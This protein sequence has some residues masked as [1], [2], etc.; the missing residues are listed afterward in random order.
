[1]TE[2]LGNVP[3]GLLLTFFLEKIAPIVYMMAINDAHMRAQQHALDLHGA[4]FAQEF[5]YWE[6][7]DTK[8]RRR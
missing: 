3:A 1:M 7:V 5:T 4:L 8:R 2:P 6:K